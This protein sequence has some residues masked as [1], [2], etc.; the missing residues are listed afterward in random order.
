[1]SDYIKRDALVNFI[2]SVRQKLSKESKDFFT[3]DEMLLNFEQYINCT[4][5]APVRREVHAA[6][7]KCSLCGWIFYKC[8]ACGETISGYPMYKYCHSCGATMDLDAKGAQP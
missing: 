6:W 5:A 2:K 8:T 4:P 7:K 1:M 3:R